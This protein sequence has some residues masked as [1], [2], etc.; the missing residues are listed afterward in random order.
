MATNVGV[1]EASVRARTDRLKTDARNVKG[2]FGTM[3][4]NITGNMRVIRTAVSSLAITLG[5]LKLGSTIIELGS[6]AEETQ[7]KFDTAFKGIREEAEKTA[8]ALSK[9]YKMSSTESKK[10]LSDT[11][12]LLKGFGFTSKE[13]LG[14]S[15]GVQELSADLASYNNL[16]GGTSRA[17]EILTKALL[18]ERDALISLG[19]KI[20]EADVKAELMKKGQDK[21]TGTALMSA[22]AWA[23]YR[24]VL[25]QTKDAQGDM[26]RTGGSFANQMKELRAKLSDLGTAIG[27]IVLPYITKFVTLLN[28]VFKKAPS[29]SGIRNAFA[30]IIEVI[31]DVLRVVAVFISN[32]SLA[33]EQI[34]QALEKLKPVFEKILKGDLAGAFDEF[35][36]LAG[37]GILK[38]ISSLNLIENVIAGIIPKIMPTLRKMDSLF[39]QSFGFDKAQADMIASDLSEF[40]ERLAMTVF[41]AA[42]VVRSSIGQVFL[43]YSPEGVKQV[44][45]NIVDVWEEG[46]APLL[47]ATSRIVHRVTENI[48][49]FLEQ[50][51]TE[52]GYWKEYFEYYGKEI[53][54]SLISGMK[55]KFSSLKEVFADLGKTIQGYGENIVI[56]FKGYG[57]NIVEGLGIGITEKVGI[58]KDAI[59]GVGKTI[60]KKFTGD[61]IIKSPSRLFKKFG[62]WITEGLSLGI[63]SNLNKVA[64]SMDDVADQIRKDG[65]EIAEVSGGATGGT[66]TGG[67]GDGGTGDT[68][69]S[70]T[71]GKTSISKS[72]ASA[73]PVIGA[74]TEGLTSGVVALITSSETW[75]ETIEKLLPPIMEI[76]DLMGVTLKPVLD[77]VIDV[78]RGLAYVT[79]WLYNEVIVGVANGL[80]SIIN[81][82]IKLVNKIPGIDIKQV[83]YMKR[84]YDMEDSADGASDSIDNMAKASDG[85]S[86]SFFNLSKK[87]NMDILRSRVL[88]GLEGGSRAS[89]VTIN[90]ETDNGTYG[91]AIK[92]DPRTG[93]ILK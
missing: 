92:V 90:V 25:G 78:F 72:L 26:A 5:A 51:V 75:K 10:L 2:I 33:F 30:D 67:T 42:K 79:R 18:G 12:D 60:I 54:D 44:A 86:A 64:D 63:V 36:N 19:V 13:A 24:L 4:K 65:E 27:K 93:V 31:A 83:A 76:V 21:L 56:K 81:G 53:I 50:L 47:L 48:S 15:N 3:T 52:I 74:F 46:L 91:T 38:A 85:V 11:G 57:E 39:I 16:Q 43:G 73:I 6:D 45:Q 88:G 89:T 20:S 69:D 1:I 82:V 8:K 37:E 40:S 62:A 66:A 70:G 58:A 17:S 29:T 80:I 49:M 9:N 7:G 41:K 87:V 34:G 59:G 32:I 68:G 23:T 14:L 22:R 71:K 35:G 28:D 77:L 61:M 55:S 84:T